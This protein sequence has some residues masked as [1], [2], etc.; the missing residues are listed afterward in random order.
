MK[1]EPRIVLYKNGENKGAL[2]TKSRGIL[3]AKGKYIM[4]LDEDDI[5]VQRDAFSYLYSEAEK[6]NVD[7]IKFIFRHSGP[8]IPKYIPNTTEHKKIIKQPELSNLLLYYDSKG[9]IIKNGGVI[10]N[11]FVKSNLYK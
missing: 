11:L 4:I 1:T 6:N 5:F 7:I 10:V 3:N 8:R 9:R 2:Y